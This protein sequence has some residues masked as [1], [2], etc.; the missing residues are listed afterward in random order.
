MIAVRAGAYFD[1][2]AVPDRTI[3]RQYLD[4][5]KLGL[6][7]GASLHAAGWRFDAALDGIIPTTRTVA[8]NAMDVMGF[9]PLVNK[10]PGDYRGTLLTFE[11]AAARRF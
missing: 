4:A 7:G 9:T 8:N 11:L 3:E 10:A 5:N 1:T 2:S 6:S